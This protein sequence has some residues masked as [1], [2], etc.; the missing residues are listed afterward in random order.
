MKRIRQF[1]G[2]IPGLAE[3]ERN[4]GDQATWKGYRRR[5]AGKI[6]YQ[7]LLES[8]ADLQHRLCGY[9]EIN[10]RKGD[11]QVEH[12]VPRSDPAQ[13]Q[14]L[15]LDAANMIACC[16]GG[17]SDAPEVLQDQERISSLGKSCGLAKGD[18]AAPAF[19]DPRNLPDLPS[20]MHV[21]PNGRIEADASA[22]QAAKRS[23]NDVEKTIEILGLNVQRLQRARKDYWNNLMQVMGEYQGDSNAI[24]NWAQNWLLP[25]SG[26][27]RKFFTTSRSYF[28]ELGER[29][30]AEE[31]RDWI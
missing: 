8:L 14:A 12:V 22:C 19:V 29:I 21:Q 4:A 6:R 3:Y 9:C 26:N 7:E 11:C 24:R 23:A 10:L 20:L 25:Q 5:P 31:P 16:L 15:E 28:G 13:G 17:A 1:Q 18:S 30:L 2:P 27:L